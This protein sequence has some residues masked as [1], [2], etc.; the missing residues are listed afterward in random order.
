MS[1]ELFSKDTNQLRQFYDP[2]HKRGSYEIE[3]KGLQRRDEKKKGA[4]AATLNERARSRRAQSKEPLL[5][6]IGDRIL[7]ISCDSNFLQRHCFPS[8]F[9]LS[10]PELE[11]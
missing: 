7:L 3:R 6:G 9:L 10:R 8:V 1:L 11:Y 5:A 4:H 2:F